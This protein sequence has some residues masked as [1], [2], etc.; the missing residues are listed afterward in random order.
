MDKN[1][2]NKIKGKK[3]GTVF[4]SLYEDIKTGL[5]FF[6]VQVIEDTLYYF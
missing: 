6:S 2:N 5:P 1:P 4:V 3:L